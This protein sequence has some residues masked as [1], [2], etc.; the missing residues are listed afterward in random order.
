L[1]RRF[2][3]LLLAPEYSLEIQARIP[4][5]LC[6]IH[7]SIRTYD[8]DE[9]FVGPDLGDDDA[10]HYH[11]HDHIAPAAPAA[12]LERPSA[13][14]DFIAQQMWEDYVRI[15]NERSFEDQEEDEEDSTE[16]EEDGAEDEDDDDE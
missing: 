11:N 6:A 2:R 16:D 7:N 14:Q 1:K 4:A 9:N 12:E 10:P 3:I 15:C 5:A 13:R 8:I